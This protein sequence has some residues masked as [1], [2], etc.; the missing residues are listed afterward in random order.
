MARKDEEKT[1]EER[2]CR[3]LRKAISAAYALPERGE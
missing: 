1:N 2:V 3:V